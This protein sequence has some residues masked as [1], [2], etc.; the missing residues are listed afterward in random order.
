MVDMSDEKTPRVVWKEKLTGHPDRS[1]FWRG[2]L[3]IPCGYQG[4]LFEK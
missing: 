1:F 3:V 2:K 4:L